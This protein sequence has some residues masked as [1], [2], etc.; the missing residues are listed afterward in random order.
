MD[1][2]PRKS[3]E[4]QIDYAPEGKITHLHLIIGAQ[5]LSVALVSQISQSIQKVLQ[6]HNSRYSPSIASTL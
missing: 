6:Y 3:N 2:Y 4:F 1:P 5:N